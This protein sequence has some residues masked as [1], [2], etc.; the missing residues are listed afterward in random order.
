MF[1]SPFQGS[2]TEISDNDDDKSD[3]EL[4]IPVLFGVERNFRV[5]TCIVT[6]D[7][8]YSSPEFCDVE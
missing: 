2:N 5:S 4:E 6:T 8:Q 7:L 3:K 1:F